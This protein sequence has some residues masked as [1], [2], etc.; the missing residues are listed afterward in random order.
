[1]PLRTTSPCAARGADQF[2]IET[3][4]AVVGCAPP[5]RAYATSRVSAFRTCSCPLGLIGMLA[6]IAA[7]ERFFA[8]RA[9][10]SGPTG[11]VEMS[12]QDAAPPPAAPKDIQTYFALVTAGSS[13]VSCRM[14]CTTGY[15]SRS[16]IWPFWAGRLP[17]VASCCGG[18][19]NAEF[20]LVPWWSISRRIL[21]T[22]A[23]SRNAAC[24]ADG[25][26]WRESLDVAWHSED[27]GC[28]ISTALHWLL[29]G[30]CDQSE[31]SLLLSF[32]SQTRAVTLPL[33][34][35]RVFERNW[36][37]NGGAQVGAPRFRA[38]R[39]STNVRRWNLAASSGKRVLCRRAVCAWPKTVESQS[40]G[41]CRRQCLHAASDWRGTA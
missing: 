6:M 10:D 34:D 33:V 15:I 19:S 13:W 40:T 11:R 4:P 31:R 8:P 41:S 35:F 28:A 25:I 30:W 26:G 16:T 7:V 18:C 22:F 23:P 5:R 21:L 29:P 14:C 2:T 1:M 36:R 39:T 17:A 9:H 12:W 37:I 32:G 3:R 24:W 20:G 38:G 27:P